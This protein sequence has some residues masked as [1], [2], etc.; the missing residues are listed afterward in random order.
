MFELYYS[1]SCPYCKKVMTYFKENNIDFDPKDV[2]FRENYEKLME[3]G[4]IPQ[5][6][7][8]YDTE[9]GNGLYESTNIIDYAQ[10]GRNNNA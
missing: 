5:I 7:F 4:K 10:K 9:T 2:T 6:P 8:L 1:E 3:L